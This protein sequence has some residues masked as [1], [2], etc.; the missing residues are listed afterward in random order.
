MLDNLVGYLNNLQFGDVL[1]FFVT[2]AWAGLW[3]KNA[4]TDVM[5]KHKESV[6]LEVKTKSQSAT[7]IEDVNKANA[8]ITKMRNDLDK[9]FLDIQKTIDDDIKKDNENFEK[10][11]TTL[12]EFNQLAMEY[13]KKIGLLENRVDKME[14]QIDLLFKSDKEYFRAFIIEGYNKYV[15][16]EKSID[17][18]SLQNL[19]SIYNKYLEEDGGKD[20]FLAKL[21]KELRN[22]PTTKRKERD[23][24]D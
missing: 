1:L 14:K 23:G 17:L 2:F 24:I 10:L 8:E 15:K 22:L 6:E 12:S 5:K 13:I 11:E 9:K 18:V 16:T 7:L 19:E 3:I 4:I 20:E 21:M